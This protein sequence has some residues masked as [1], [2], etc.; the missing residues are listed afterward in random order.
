[1]CAQVIAAKN[2]TIV[3]CHTITATILCGHLLIL[4]VYTGALAIGDGFF[5]LGEDSILLDE[6]Q[7]VGNEARLIDCPRANDMMIGQHD[8]IHFEDAGVE[9]QKN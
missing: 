2:G 8:C 4:F 5:G 9:C 7:C 3:F 6:V 1:M